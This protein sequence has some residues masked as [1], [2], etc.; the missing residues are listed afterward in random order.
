MT[1]TWSVILIV[2]CMGASKAPPVLYLSYSTGRRYCDTFH[3]PIG[4]L[5]HGTHAITCSVHI[6]SDS[7]CDGEIPA[8]VST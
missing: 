3:A 5:W 8:E 2:F 1:V 7:L 6:L 4:Y